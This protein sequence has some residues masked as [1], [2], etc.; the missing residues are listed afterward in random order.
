MRKELKGIAENK[1]S[2]ITMWEV[3]AE[4]SDFPVIVSVWYTV[5]SPGFSWGFSAD[6]E[7]VR[8]VTSKDKGYQKIYSH[9]LPYPYPTD[10]LYLPAV[11]ATHSSALEE[12]IK[13]GFIQV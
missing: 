9:D 2:T 12:A 10:D 3:K 7:A 11:A 4:E 5:G 8:F 13:Q 1:L 6:G